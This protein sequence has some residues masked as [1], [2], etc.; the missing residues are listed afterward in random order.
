MIASPPGLFETMRR[1]GAHV[2][3]LDAHLT[4]LIASARA[5][6]FAALDGEDLRHRCLDRASE[7]HRRSPGDGVLRLQVGCAGGIELLARPIREASLPLVADLVVMPSSMVGGR[8]KSVDRAFWDEVRSGSAPDSADAILVHPDGEVLEATVA[9]V[10]ARV[11]GGWVTP[12]TDGRILPGIGRAWVLARLQAEGLDVEER[13]L[14]VEE[15]RAASS[16][17]LTNAV[18]GARPACLRG[19]CGDEPRPAVPAC[20]AWP[21]GAGSREPRSTG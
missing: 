10:F 14:S 3:L 18:H 20:L 1:V 8:H 5:S 19:A 13:R 11:G 21:P 6:S 7:E 16:I 12:P 17:L 4:R 2:P 9:N 15:L